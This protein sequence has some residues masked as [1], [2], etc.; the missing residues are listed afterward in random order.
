MPTVAYRVIRS[1]RKFIKAPAVKKYLEAGL[2]SEVKPYF[3]DKFEVIV[4][5]WKHKPDFKAR[6]FI[7]AD[8]IK[9]NVFPAGEHKKIYIYVT[10]GTRAHVIRPKRARTLAFMWGGKGSYRPKTT[11]APSWR[12]PG[13]VVGG[14]MHFAKQVHHPGTK[15]RN[16]EKWVKESSK[17][18]FSRTMENMWRR[19]ICQ[20]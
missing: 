16:F 9:V 19:A 20:L 11:P 1:R 12:G 6:K 18:W 4:A 7:A 14:A 10:K 3:T 13:V 2:D 8:Y 5:D 17:G 15:A